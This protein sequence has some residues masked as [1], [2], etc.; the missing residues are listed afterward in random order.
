MK[1]AGK[2]PGYFLQH[3]GLTCACSRTPSSPR[4]RRPKHRSPPPHR[5][6]PPVP[7]LALRQRLKGNV[8]RLSLRSRRCES[9]CVLTTLY[10]LHLQ[11]ENWKPNSLPKFQQLQWLW[12]LEWGI[13]DHQQHYILLKTSCKVI[14]EKHRSKLFL[15]SSC[16]SRS[17]KS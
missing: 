5:G 1:K 15:T 13:T 10:L 14:G 8:V 7:A 16:W 4:T 11:R 12:S 17:K 9:K 2:C 3:P 6:R